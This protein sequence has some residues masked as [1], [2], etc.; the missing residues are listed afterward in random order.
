MSQYFPDCLSSRYGFE[1]NLG[2]GGILSNLGCTI[3]LRKDDDDY[4]GDSRVLLKDDNRY[5]Y[6]IFGWGSCE[7]CDALQA[8]DS[9]QDL[10]DLYNKLVD[11]IQWKNSA[12]EM[13]DWISNRD[14]ATQYE[15]HA[16]DTREFLQDAILLLQKAKKIEH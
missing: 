13:L 3:L 5:G 7:G 10:A 1:P 14:W 15:W 8:C 11:S 16:E 12:E 9:Y 2:Y 6:L 4:Q